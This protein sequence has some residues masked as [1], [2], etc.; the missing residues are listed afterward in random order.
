M[1]TTS[2]HGTRYR[3]AAALLLVAA[4]MQAGARR[5]CAAAKGLEAWLEKRRLAAAAF[6]DFGT[7]GERDLL[8]IGLT[9]ADLHRV[10]WG[11]SDRFQEPL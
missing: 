6:H 5:L 2:F 8:D 1:Q 7:M 3:S 9:R 11:V 10:A 4:V